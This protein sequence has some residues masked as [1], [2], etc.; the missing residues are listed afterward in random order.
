[1]NL[2]A[3]PGVDLVQL[4]QVQQVKTEEAAKDSCPMPTKRKSKAESSGNKS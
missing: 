3:G 1:M 4:S 2:S